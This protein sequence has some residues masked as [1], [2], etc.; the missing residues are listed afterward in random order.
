MG[1]QEWQSVLVVASAVLLGI[2]TVFQIRAIVKKAKAHHLVWGIWTIVNTASMGALFFAGVSPWEQWIPISQWLSTLA[3][4]A[5]SIIVTPKGRWR[6]EPISK[7]DKVALGV[8]LAGV[9]AGLVLN[10]PFV[11]LWGNFIANL[12]GLAPMLK[13]GRRNPNSINRPYVVFRGLASVLACAVFMVNG[14]D[15]AGLIPQT[16]GL[17]IVG[18]MLY[19]GVI[20]PKRRPAPSTRVITVRPSSPNPL[21]FSAGVLGWFL[22]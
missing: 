17:I 11:A 21:W 4:L 9:G 5:T 3:L 7:G 22:H 12:A 1:T 6:D 15:V 2:A 10:E 14:V 13:E 19:V 8:C 20:L 16:M 18:S